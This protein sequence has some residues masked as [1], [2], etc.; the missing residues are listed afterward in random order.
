MK[1][2]PFFKRGLLYQSM[3]ILCPLLILT[4]SGKANATAIKVDVASYIANFVNVTGKVLDPEGQP[5]IGATVTI[6]GTKASAQTDETGTFRLNVPP[7]S[8]I[9]VI[10]YV[11]FK[12]QEVSINNR[13]AIN[14]Q[15]ERAD[16]ALEEVVVVGYGT[17]KKAHL[18]GAVETVDMKA[19]E[20]LPA[21]NLGAGL[22]GRI[23]GLGVSGGTARPGAKAT[24]T[25]RK[26]VIYGKDSGT[27]EPLYVI[28]GMIQVDAQINR[29]QLS[30]II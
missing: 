7:G 22:A 24:L 13:T 4:P 8:D 15:M 30:L 12:T 9:L 11:G 17:Q 16:D 6:K 5:V 26:P 2:K 28:D 19:I 3:G 20:D 25:V 29:K 23:A 21:T 10:T 18:T 1:F 14:I 27:G